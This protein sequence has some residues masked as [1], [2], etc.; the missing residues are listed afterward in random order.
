MH[1]DNNF[2]ILYKILVFLQIDIFKSSAWRIGA[3]STL[4]PKLLQSR[5]KVS[6]NLIHIKSPQQKTHP[7]FL[8]SGVYSVFIVVVSVLSRIINKRGLL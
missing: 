4:S 2:F 8:E 5:K 6:P 7:Q 1:T 3:I